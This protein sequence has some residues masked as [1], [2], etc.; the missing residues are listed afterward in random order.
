MTIKGNSVATV[1]ERF[2]KTDNGLLRL[3]QFT[4]KQPAKQ[5]NISHMSGFTILFRTGICQ[6]IIVQ[7][8]N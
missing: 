7:N 5:K 8:I 2:V 6:T 3:H 1:V 4:D